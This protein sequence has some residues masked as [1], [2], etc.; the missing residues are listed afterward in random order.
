MGHARAIAGIN[1]PQRQLGL[2]RKTIRRNLSVR[3]VEQ[4]ASTASD[5]TGEKPTEKI[6][7]TAHL[8]DLAQALTRAAGLKVTVQ[9]GKRK[10]SGRV[11]L[12]YASLDQFDQ[13]AKYLGAKNPTE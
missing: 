3:Q 9:A 6:A 5:P 10:N 1:D 8:K 7:A 2:A 12:H 11:V 13:I 4:L